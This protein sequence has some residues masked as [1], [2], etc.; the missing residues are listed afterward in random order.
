MLRLRGRGPYAVG[1]DAPVTEAR[2]APAGSPL[3]RE[4][5]VPVQLAP[6]ATVAVEGGR[7]RAVAPCPSG[8][9]LLVIHR[10]RSGDWSLPKGKLEPGETAVAAALARGPRGDRVALRPRRRSRRDALRRSQGASEARPVLGDAHDGGPLPSQR[11]GRQD[12]WL[13]A[14]DVLARLTYAHDVSLIERNLAASPRSPR[15]DASGSS[16]RP[17][18]DETRAMHQVAARDASSA[19]DPVALVTPEL[20]ERFRRDGVVLLPQALHPEWLL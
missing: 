2:P 12:R 16:A 19:A 9:E 11:R 4:L 6:P 20:I 13:G 15:P 18:G 1:R 3:R 14:D 5:P 17:S 10:P 7:R 8:L